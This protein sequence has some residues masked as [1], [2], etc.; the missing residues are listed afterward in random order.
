MP[1]LAFIPDC[2]LLSKNNNN[3][4]FGGI[5]LHVLRHF[6]R[7]RGASHKVLLF[8]VQKV[9]FSLSI[10]LSLRSLFHI[11]L[12]FFF[13]YTVVHIS[14]IYWGW[15]ADPKLTWSA[16]QILLWP[17]G[18]VDVIRLALPLCTPLPTFADGLTGTTLPL[19]YKVFVIA[20]AAWI[21]TVPQVLT[22][23]SDDDIEAEVGGA[24]T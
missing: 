1:I 21:F 13:L 7:P 19:S 9:R 20:H 3:N 10:K 23:S 8:D 22:M 24:S 11:G 6:P 2:L 15:S 17:H 12:D 18:L 14:D 16:E 4:R 5:L